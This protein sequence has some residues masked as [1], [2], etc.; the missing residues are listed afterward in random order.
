[1]RT[2]THAHEKKAP[3][4]YWIEVVEMLDTERSNIRR[5]HRSIPRL[6]V[7]ITIVEPGSDLER[8][9]NRK[10][11]KNPGQYGEIRYD[12]MSPKS[13]IDKAKA[14]RRYRDTVQRLMARGFTVNGDTTTWHIYVIELDNSH[15]PNCPGYFYVGQTTKPVVERIEQH[16][17][18]VRRGS[19]ILY[20]REAHRYFR[21]W[22]PDIGPKGPFFSE[23]AALQAE[24]LTRVMLE[25]RGYTVT[26][27]SE[28][29][30][31]AQGRRRPARPRPPRE[32]RTPS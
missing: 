12:L 18:G 5:R 32:P 22:R 29:Y 30:E 17:Q 28:R 6:F 13:T 26:G 1:M 9:W 2:H 14:D 8:R 10:R 3:S 4:R 24:S 31:W 23:E 15:R 16:R 27:G 11:S 7:G 25:N 20:S 19:G 21:A